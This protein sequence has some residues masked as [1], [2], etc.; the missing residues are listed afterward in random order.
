M[1]PVDT[2]SQGILVQSC[3]VAIAEASMATRHSM[4]QSAL[5][6]TGPEEQAAIKSRH[7]WL[8][9]RSTR[10]SR[11]AKSPCGCAGACTG[12]LARLGPRLVPANHPAQRHSLLTTT[13][14]H[15]HHHNN[16]S[17]NIAPA[18]FLCSDKGVG[19]QTSKQANRLGQD[20]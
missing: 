20:T 16:A 1:P 6:S 8:P 5:E 19:T 11:V 9:D 12:S 15:H 10:G 18:C 3:H 14:H 2:A 7:S 17:L 4:S 13:H